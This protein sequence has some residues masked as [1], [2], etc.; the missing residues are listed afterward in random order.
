MANNETMTV[1]R[2]ELLTFYSVMFVLSLGM[3]IGGIYV[4]MV[5]ERSKPTATVEV[6]SN[7]KEA[8]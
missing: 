3:F 8:R 5:I 6:Q 2:R 1:T 4:G 7:P